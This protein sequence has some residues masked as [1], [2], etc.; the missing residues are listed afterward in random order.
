MTRIA[1]LTA[2]ALLI[3]GSPALAQDIKGT[4]TDGALWWGTA[5]AAGLGP[6]E[7]PEEGF[8]RLTCADTRTELRV[9][10]PYPIALD[11]RGTVDLTVDSRTWR[12]E[13]RGAHEQSTGITALSAITVPEDALSALAG[14]A[15]ARFDMP[16][17]SRRIHLT[18]SG[19]AL[20]A[21][22]C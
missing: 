13:G 17:E 2:A 4:C 8:F 10:S 15:A 6:C 5:S 21:L 20:A 11:Q 7:S 9:N 22:T 3:A 18:G 12:L 1:A 16:T 19:A 14:G